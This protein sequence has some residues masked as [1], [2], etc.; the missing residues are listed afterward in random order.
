MSRAVIENIRTSP[1]VCHH[2]RESVRRKSSGGAKALAD[3][4]FADFQIFA[5]ESDLIILNS[6]LQDWI[7]FET[8]PL[9]ARN[10]EIRSPRVPRPTGDIPCITIPSP[11]SSHRFSEH[12]F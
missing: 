1:T 2:N 12:E 9:R 3:G 7:A 5:Q 6:R 4:P 10:G 8:V 11:V